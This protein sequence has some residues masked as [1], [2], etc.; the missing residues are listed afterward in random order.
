MSY[1]RQLHKYLD[2][3]TDKRIIDFSC[4]RIRKNIS[5]LKYH[6]MIYTH[7]FNM[8]TINS[9]VAKGFLFLLGKL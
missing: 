5:I 4:R 9:D 3:C 8:Y 1:H 2:E 7:L 6:V